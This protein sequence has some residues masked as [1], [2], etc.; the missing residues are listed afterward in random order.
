MAEYTI[1]LDY[2]TLSVRALLLDTA[3]GKEK[4]VSA[5]DYPHGVME[6]ELP[7]GEGLPKGSAL[8]QPQDYLD[9]L[10]YTVNDVMRNA[11]VA[12]EEIV[13]IGIDAT[14]STL[15]PVNAE[16]VPLCFTEKFAKEPHAY[17]K[18]WKHHS[19]EEE[20]AVINKIAKE[21]GEKWLS[22]YGG[23]I[24]SEWALPKVLETLKYAPEVYD[25]AD[26]FIDAVDWIV[27]QLTGEESRSACVMGYKAFYDSENGFPSK[28]FFRAI[29]PKL[30]NFVEE[31]INSPIKPIGKAAGC[32]TEKMSA[33]LGLRA[34]IPVATGILDA[35]ASVLGAGINKPGE[36]MIVMG[37]SSCYLLLSEE[38]IEVPGICGIVKD[39][40]CP[41]TTATRPGK[42]VW[43]TALRGLYAIAC[44]KAI[45]ARPEKEG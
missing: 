3:S 10:L 23:R 22:R 45:S 8:Q 34:G 21:R 40:F 27:W 33:L 9:G 13:G 43:E 35:H 26:S 12:P 31:K 36:L 24:S 18:M 28:D 41:A 11:G 17:M 42:A 4:Y 32:L 5:F 19:C 6:A 37:T 15:L 30:E 25:E 1:G 29:H 2:G 38:F 44:R 14:G 16:V 20:A 7:T 39:A